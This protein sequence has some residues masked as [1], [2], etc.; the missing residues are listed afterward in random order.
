MTDEKKSL[1]EVYLAH[2]GETEW[3]ITGQ[4][5]GRTDLPLTDRGERN[6]RSLGAAGGDVVRPRLREPA[7]AGVA[8]VRAGRVRRARRGR[9][10]AAGVG[11]WRVRGPSYRRDPRGA[12]RLVPVPRRLPGGRVGRRGRRPGP[13]PWS[14]APGARRRTLLFGHSHF[15][16][17]LAARWLGLPAGDARLF[18]LS[19]ASL[20][21]LGYEH[22]RDEP[23]LRLW[24]DDRHVEE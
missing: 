7:A 14:R 4:H 1:P 8:D 11:L 2:H 10:R 21:I 3:T 22:G 12:A 19:T 16:R 24:N 6:A 17:V 15:F 20:S 9:P 18:L 23:A 13:T 5:T